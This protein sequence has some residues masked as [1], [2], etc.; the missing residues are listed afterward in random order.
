MIREATAMTVRKNLGDLLNEVRYHHDSVVI[1]KAGKPI[2]ALI[3][4]EFFE[5]IRS[6]RKQFDKLT[7]ELGSIYQNI[8]SATAE[9]EIA[10]AIKKAKSAK[11]Q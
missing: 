8:N 6:M 10:E 4:I 1:T 7:A 9:Q 3:D 2:A 11:D 5:K